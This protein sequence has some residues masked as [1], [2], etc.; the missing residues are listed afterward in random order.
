[1][2]RSEMADILFAYA[3]RP[4]T[5]GIPECEAAALQPWLQLVE[6]INA[7][8]PPVQPSPTFVRSLGRELRR[9]A[10]QQIAQRERLQRTLLIG[11]AVGSIVSI[12][13]IAG[14]VIFVLLRRRGRA[15][16]MQ[17]TVV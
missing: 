7:A 11:A 14:A 16:V 12:A 5:L 8:M 9:R 2:K 6:R 4:D 3:E 10:G 1:M 15:Q 13:S 17:S